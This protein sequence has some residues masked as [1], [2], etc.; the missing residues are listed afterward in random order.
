MCVSYFQDLVGMAWDEVDPSKDLDEANR[1][2]RS[3]YES[4]DQIAVLFY[5]VGEFSKTRISQLKEATRNISID[6]Q[7]RDVCHPLDLVCFQNLDAF[8]D[9]LLEIER[10]DCEEVYFLP[11]PGGEDISSCLE[12]RLATE[13]VP[14]RGGFMKVV[15]DVK[16]SVFGLPLLTPDVLD[17][18]PPFVYWLDGEFRLSR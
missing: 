10:C 6:V 1:I 11:V 8:L 5:R 9:R 16:T 7:V 14:P 17:R 2:F 4:D 13:E 3:V 15:D 18:F 12:G